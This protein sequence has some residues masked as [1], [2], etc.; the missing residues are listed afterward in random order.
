MKTLEIRLSVAQ[1]KMFHD[2]IDNTK[3]VHKDT[4]PFHQL[5]IDIKFKLSFGTIKSYILP[6]FQ[7]AV[8]F[9]N[10]LT[11]DITNIPVKTNFSKKEKVL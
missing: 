6:F 11:K 7:Q 9:W 4:L 1:L 3:E 2:L 8:R 5:C 10:R